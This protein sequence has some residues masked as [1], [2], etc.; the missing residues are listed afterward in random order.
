VLLCVER[1]DGYRQEFPLDITLAGVGAQVTE[2]VV[3]WLPLD[4]LTGLEL[5]A[6]EVN[7]GLRAIMGQYQRAIPLDPSSRILVGWEDPTAPVLTNHSRSE[8]ISVSEIASLR[9]DFDRSVP[10]S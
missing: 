9:L 6:D 7:P 4:K 8:S 3:E 5:D 10:G 2:G 1:V